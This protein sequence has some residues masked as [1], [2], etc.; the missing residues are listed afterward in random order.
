ME[1]I[2]KERHLAKTITWRVIAT[3]DTFLIAWIVTGEINWAAGIA[4]IEVLTKMI[5]YY[6]HERI[7]YKYIRFGVRNV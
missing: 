5:L 7:W 4:G 6:F 1:K 3:S 2:K